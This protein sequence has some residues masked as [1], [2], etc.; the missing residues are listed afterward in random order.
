MLEELKSVVT[1][2]LKVFCIRIFAEYYNSDIKS[3]VFK[4]DEVKK[5]L[6]PHMNEI[7]GPEIYGR[8]LCLLMNRSDVGSNQN[9]V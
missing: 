7:T 5:K 1:L 2:S 9:L 3:G 8:K 6:L 4:D